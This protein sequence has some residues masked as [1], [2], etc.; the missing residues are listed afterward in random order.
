MNIKKEFYEALPESMENYHPYFLQELEETGA[1]EEI[2]GDARW[3]CEDSKEEFKKIL[4]R[5]IV[6]YL[7]MGEV[8]YEYL[9]L[10]K[11]TGVKISNYAFLAGEVEEDMVK[12]VTVVPVFDDM[13]K[14]GEALMTITDAE[15]IARGETVEEWKKQVWKDFRL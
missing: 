12:N 6:A 7:K 8:I 2:V 3:Q 15:D 13:V 9:D 14:I 10:H 5:E 1:V 4:K 11:L